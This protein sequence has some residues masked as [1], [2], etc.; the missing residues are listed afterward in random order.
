MWNFGNP[1]TFV[2]ERRTAK[3]KHTHLFFDG[4]DDWRCGAGATTVS[5]LHDT[6]DMVKVRVRD[7]LIVR[8]TSVGFFDYTGCSFDQRYIYG[9]STHGD[10]VGKEIVAI[11][12]NQSSLNIWRRL[13]PHR[14]FVNNIRDQPDPV[15]S[16]NG[17]MVIF[18]TNWQGPNTSTISTR[19]FPVMI[20]DLVSQNGWDGG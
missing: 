17:D 10:E 5:G 11:R 16:R 7:G 19:R 4:T 9:T 3:I 18:D 6:G 14:A 13:G 8:L 1:A 2:G 12:A 15:A 20:Y